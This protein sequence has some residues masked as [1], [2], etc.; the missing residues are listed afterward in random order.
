MRWRERERV[1]ERDRERSNFT[2]LLT[3]ADLRGSETCS[4]RGCK[5]SDKTRKDKE[6]AYPYAAQKI[7]SVLQQ[8]TLPK[9]EVAR[10][11]GMPFTQLTSHPTTQGSQCESCV[12]HG[13]HGEEVIASFTDYIAPPVNCNNYQVWDEP[14][15]PCRRFKTRSPRCHRHTSP[16]EDSQVTQSSFRSVLRKHC[17]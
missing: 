8:P 13:Q 10:Q 6:D 15:F 9:Y 16:V 7:P 14:S 11:K 4:Q 1:R 5:D 2:L 3:L 17:Q 12:L